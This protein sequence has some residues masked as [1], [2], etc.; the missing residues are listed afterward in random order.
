MGRD[1]AR[2]RWPRLRSAACCSGPRQYLPNTA[3]STCHVTTT[4][5]SGPKPRAPRC[6][7]IVLCTRRRTV[8]QGERRPERGWPAA[9]CA[10]CALGAVLRSDWGRDVT[11]ARCR[12]I[13]AHRLLTAAIHGRFIALCSTC[14]MSGAPGIR[15]RAAARDA[16]AAR[17]RILTGWVLTVSAILSGLFAGIAAA[18]APGHK[19]LPRGSERRTQ[20]TKSGQTAPSAATST[21]IPPL[22]AAPGPG[23][24]GAA[25]PP[26]PTPAPAPTPTQSPPV[27]VSGG[28]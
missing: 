19:L 16:L 14:P 10:S 1:S 24:V 8:K 25:A 5:K 21:V 7:V 22:P 11:K 2:T 27:V 17:T 15:Q 28:S 23:D 9:G 20:T 4:T 13:P 12:K 3:G 26:A 18:S 6:Y